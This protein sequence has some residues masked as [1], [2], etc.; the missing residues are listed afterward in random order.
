MRE[1]TRKKGRHRRRLQWRLGVVCRAGTSCRLLAAVAAVVGVAV[2]VWLAAAPYRGVI[3]FHDARSCTAIHAATAGAD[4][5]ILETGSVVH[6][7]NK[8]ICGYPGSGCSDSYELTVQRPSGETTIDVDHH[9]YD[10]AR[11][12]SRADLQL[13]LGDVAAITVNG[14]TAK[15]IIPVEIGLFGAI[16]LA[17]AG[18]GLLLGSFLWYVQSATP[19]SRVAGNLVT[20]VIGWLVFGGIAIAV[21]IGQIR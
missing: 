15:V 9:T 16:L 14:K 18:L 21:A 19:R 2:G 6:K 3:A 5:I 7:Y 20:A 17:W 11:T 10:A 4:C 12:G 1:L 8:L 13:W